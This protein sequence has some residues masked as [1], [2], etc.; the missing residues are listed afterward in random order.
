[1]DSFNEFNRYMAHLSEG[2]GQAYRDA[3]LLLPVFGRY[4]GCYWIIDDT[5]FP[6]GRENIR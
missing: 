6:K 3:E 2:L 5:C 4:S 1:M